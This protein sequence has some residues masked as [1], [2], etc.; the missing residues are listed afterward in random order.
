MKVI[1]LRKEDYVLTTIVGYIHLMTTLVLDVTAQDGKGF[2]ITIV[3]VMLII[4]IRN[5]DPIL[6]GN[7]IW[8]FIGALVE[9]VFYFN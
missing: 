4:A 2:G 8:H 6:T 1:F 7:R 3:R 5:G 9:V